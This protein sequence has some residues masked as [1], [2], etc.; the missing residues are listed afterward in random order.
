MNKPIVVIMVTIMVLST[1]ARADAEIKVDVKI[2]ESLFVTYEF[3]NLDPS[4]YEQARLGF[5]PEKIPEAI[6][7]NYLE[8]RNQTIRWGLS[9]SPLESNDNTRTIRNSF[10][11]SGS[12]IV[13]FTLNKTTLKPVYEIK[14]DWRKFKLNLTSSYSIDFAQR[15]AEPAAR[16]QRPT[17]TTFNY[18]NKETDAPDIVFNI[19]LPDSASAVRVQGD[20]IFYEGQPRLEDQLL[21]SPFLI[22]GSLTVA[23]II[24]L[25][26]RKVH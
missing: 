19:A 13:S 26:Y 8:T 4:V 22:L 15:L 24:I 1:A 9:P 3:S 7:D 10:Y 25:L 2:D 17:A 6:A 21:G 11:L 5:T 20:T 18:E 14:T 16:W 23:L 12:S